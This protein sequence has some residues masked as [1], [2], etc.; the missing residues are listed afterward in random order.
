MRK[1]HN[2]PHVIRKLHN[3]KCL[4]NS[5]VFHRRT[6][7]LNIIRMH[8]IMIY[9]SVQGKIVIFNTFCS[10]FHQN[11]KHPRRGMLIPKRPSSTRLH[12]LSNYMMLP[13]VL[14]AHHS[15]KVVYC[16]NSGHRMVTITRYRMIYFVLVIWHILWM[17]LFSWVSIVMD[18]TEIT[19]SWGSKF[20]A[21]IFSFI[22]HTKNSYFMGTGIRGLDPPRKPRQ[23]TIG[24]QRKLSHPQCT[25]FM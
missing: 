18:R 19:H 15:F 12:I 2:K 6:I 11:Y 3:S 9:L 21:I 16:S 25:C 22:P 17:A 8:S 7:S 10:D 14:Y 1:L 24:T 13:F 23:S 5:N 4:A 20:V